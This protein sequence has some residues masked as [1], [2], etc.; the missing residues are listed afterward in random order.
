[1]KLHIITGGS[2]GLGF[3]L[4]NFFEKQN[5]HVAVISRSPLKNTD[6]KKYYTYD[7]SKNLP[8]EDMIRKIFNDFNLE[9]YDQITL[10]NNAGI[11]EPI[12]YI[13]N[14]N[15]QEILNNLMVNLY[16]PISLTTA[17][18]KFTKNFDRRVVIVNI[19]S[20]VARHPKSCW[21]VYSAAK[22]GLESFS[23]ALAKEYQDSNKTKIINF[24]PG[25][26]DT[27]MQLTIRNIKKEHFD[28]LER[29]IDFKK[30][31]QLASPEL[32]ATKLGTFILK[33]NLSVE[34]FISINDL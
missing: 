8:K 23:G 13:K 25:I 11:V 7:F 19:S 17:L 12:N 30:S 14:L 33:K 9:N 27:N 34:N 6:Q 16:S 21:A 18:F 32:V 22:A 15:D 2:K 10:I 24:E 4:A 5:D 3:A 28:D 26:I 1:M 31:G 29:F 20:G